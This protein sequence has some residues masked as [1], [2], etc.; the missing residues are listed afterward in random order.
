MIHIIVSRF[1]KLLLSDMVVSGVQDATARIKRS[2]SQRYSSWDIERY[3]QATNSS[4]RID[5]NNKERPMEVKEIIFYKI[6]LTV[7]YLLIYSYNLDI[8]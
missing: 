4:V 2:Y 1:L 3:H 5:F 6:F 8:Y 7:G